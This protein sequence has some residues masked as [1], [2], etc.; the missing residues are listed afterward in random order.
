VGGGQRLARRLAS[1]EP[2]ELVLQRRQHRVRGIH[3]VVAGRDPLPRRGGELHLVAGEQLS[4]LGR[5]DLTLGQRH[6]VLEELGVD[7]LDPHAAL[8]EQRLVEPHSLAPLQHR[9]GRDP[10]LGK[11]AALEQLPQQP[12]VAAIGLGVLLATTRC[13]RVGRLGHMRLEARSGN[14][15][16]D[17]PPPG[18]ALHR[19]RR[20]VGGPRRQLV[21]QP[22]PEPLTVGLP[23][24]AAPH[25][26]AVDL[27]RVERDLT[28]MQ[29]QPTYHAH[30]EPPWSSR[31]D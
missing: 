18:A 17:I 27:Q 13:L 4:R 2:L 3:H 16:D 5:A 24:A 9:V 29:I 22:P 25:L 14:L 28:A 1:S 30:P 21:S 26:A 15:L 6:T 10:G 20:P 12:G 31:D 19:Q 11:I 8:I 7:A 23:D